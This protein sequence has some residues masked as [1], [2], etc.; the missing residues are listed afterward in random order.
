MAALYLRRCMTISANAMIAL[1]IVDTEIAKSSSFEI[2]CP[3]MAATRNRIAH[4]ITVAYAAQ[5][6]SL[7]LF[8]STVYAFSKCFGILLTLL[9]CEFE[10]RSPALQKNV[11]VLGAAL[12]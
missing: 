5:L 12:V 6:M 11:A 10:A 7:T 8:L 1:T 9:V 2:V 3:G 4:P